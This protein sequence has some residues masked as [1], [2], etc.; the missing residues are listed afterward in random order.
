MVTIGF[1][2]FSQ[3]AV[4]GRFP[5]QCYS[6]RLPKPSPKV[7]PGS[8]LEPNAAPV[9][10]QANTRKINYKTMCLYLDTKTAQ[11]TG[12]KNVCPERT[13]PGLLAPKPAHSPS[14]ITH[15]NNGKIRLRLDRRNACARVMMAVLSDQCEPVSV[16][17]TQ[18][19]LQAARRPR[20]SARAAARVCLWCCGSGGGAPSEIGC[21]PSHG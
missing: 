16:C 7:G 18:P 19:S 9:E 20:H 6:D 5:P 10:K 21:G 4:N 15:E 3:P 12:Q 1:P 13:P 17:P 11:A 2:T 8:H 14:R